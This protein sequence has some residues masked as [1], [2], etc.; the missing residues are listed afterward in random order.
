M[1]ITGGTS[2]IGLGIGRRLV[3]EGTPVVLVGR[4]QARAARAVAGL[5]HEG[6]DPAA[7][8]V[9]VGDTID[10]A[11]LR[12]AT[13]RCARRWAPVGG[14]VTAAGALARGPVSEVGPEA[15]RLVLDVNVVGTWV[16]VQSVLPT[17]VAQA[18]GRIVTIGSVLGTVGTPQRAAYAATKGAVAA[19]TRAVAVEVAGHGVT[20]NC[21]APGPVRTPMNEGDVGGPDGPA[22]ARD[23]TEAIPVGRWGE[24]ADVAHVALALLAD[25]AG[26]TTGSVV[27]VDGGYTAR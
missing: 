9:V 18:H 26:W 13:D 14:L 20:A 2:G 11:V 1:I 27:H 8:E 23:F 7:V 19:L 21:I 12:E 22:E 15:L 3:Q 6:L 16:A 10:P 4:D 17:M 24:P 25:G 5:V